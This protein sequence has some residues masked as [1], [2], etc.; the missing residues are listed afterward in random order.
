MKKIVLLFVIVIVSCYGLFAQKDKMKDPDYVNYYIVIPPI[1]GDGFSIQ[2][3]DIVSKMGYI[4]LKIRIFNNSNDYIIFKPYESIFKLA[5]GEFNGKDKIM[6]IK[7]HENESKVLDI[8]GDNKCLVDSFILLIKGLYRFSPQDVVQFTPNFQ[9]PPSLNTFT[10]G[11]FT[12]TL[13]AQKKE[14]QETWVKFGCT[15]IGENAGLIDPNKAV[16]KLENNQEFANGKSNAKASVLFKGEEDKFTLYFY[17]PATVTD[18]QFANMQVVWKN[19]FVDCPVSSID[20][21][22]INFAID[23][24][25]TIGKNKY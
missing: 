17:V 6:I 1:Q 4:K 19:T 10:N 16:I 13:L 9:I 22:K 2:F 15:Y 23:R 3:D 24:G 12:C 25:F 21:I 5:Q 18:M 14:T 7:P 8:K 11:S 20:P